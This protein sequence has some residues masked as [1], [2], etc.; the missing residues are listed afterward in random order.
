MKRWAFRLFAVI[1]LLS[2]SPVLAQTATVTGKISDP[3]GRPRA[4][5]TVSVAG[6]ISFTDIRGV[7]RIRN[8]P[9]GSQVKMQIKKNGKVIKET[10]IDIRSASVTRDERVP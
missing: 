9:W 2:A 7:Y 1:A 8:V 6:R 10:T 4:N 3:K 5:L